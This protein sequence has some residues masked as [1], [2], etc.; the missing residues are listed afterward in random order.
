ML[1]IILSWAVTIHKL[2]G[3]TVDK[4]I[5]LVNKIFA[6]GQAY[7]ALSRVR[8]LQGLAIPEIEQKGLFQHLCDESALA[9]LRRLRSVHINLV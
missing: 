2:Q 6:E 4:V 5:Y 7:V 8:S 9:E 1:P 3:T